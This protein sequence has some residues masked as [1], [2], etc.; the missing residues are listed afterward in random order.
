MQ[1][2]DWDTDVVR[3]YSDGAAALGF[4]TV[5]FIIC[6]VCL[7]LLHWKVKAYEVVR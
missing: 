4:W 5:L 3:K 1:I 7:A 6:A 2:T